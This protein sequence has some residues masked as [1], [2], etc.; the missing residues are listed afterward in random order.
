MVFSLIGKV[1]DNRLLGTEERAAVLGRENRMN[2]QVREGLAHTDITTQNGVLFIQKRPPFQGESGTAGLPRAKAPGLFCGPP[3]GGAKFRWRRYVDAYKA[4]AGSGLV[5]RESFRPGRPLP[6][7]P[8]TGGLLTKSK[9]CERSRLNPARESRENLVYRELCELLH[10]GSWLH[11]REFCL[12]PATPKQLFLFR[13]KE[14]DNDRSLRRF[15]RML[16]F[17]QFRNIN[18]RRLIGCQIRIQTCQSLMVGKHNMVCDQEVGSPVG[19]EAVSFRVERGQ[20]RL[21]NF[22][23]P[24]IASRSRRALVG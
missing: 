24:I 1:G 22:A 14:I 18:Y 12:R 15:S 10:R 2:Q 17:L 7:R 11:L 3:S 19:E 5:S 13:I 16:R 6:K 20:Q 4:A 23:S 21:T 8:A 9:I